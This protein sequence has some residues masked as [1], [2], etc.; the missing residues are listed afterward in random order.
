MKKIV[1]QSI[2]LT[3]FK[4]IRSLSI[5]FSER[6]TTVSG[7]NGTGKT[8]IFDAFLWLLFGKDSTGRSDSNFNIKTLGPDGKP[9]LKL[10]HS[11]IGVLSV[12]G[13]PVKLQRD[14]I[15]VWTKP[16]GTTQE[17]LTNHKTEFYVNDVKQPTKRDYD[18]TVGSIIPE[19]M[20]K[21]LTDPGFFPR[22]SPDAQ[23]EI[24]LDMAG[25]VSDQ[26][27]AALRPEFLEL[28]SQIQGKGLEVF[29]KEVAAKK[30]AVKDELSQI[31][32]R[33]ETAQRLRPEAEDW[34]AAEKELQTSRERIE[35]IDAQ[36]AD[37]TKLSDEET[38]RKLDIRKQIGDLQ[39]SIADRKNAIRREAEGGRTKA[40]DE[41]RELEHKVTLAKSEVNRAK[42]RVDMLTA[43]VESLNGRLANMRK[44][45]MD[46]NAEKLVFD[47][48]EFICPTCK[49]PL[50]QEDIEAKQR[51]LE[52]NFNTKKASRLKANREAGLAMKEKLSAKQDALEKAKADEKAARESLAALEAELDG[53]RG[54]VPDAP[55]LERLY[56]DDEECRSKL[57]QISELENQLTMDAKLPDVSDV[58]DEKRRLNFKIEDL[59]K[60]LGRRDAIKRADEEISALEERRVAANQSLAELEGMEALA[61][62]FQKEKDAELLRRINGMFSVV[63]FSFVASQLNGGE[64]LTC[65]CTVDGTPYPDVNNAGKINAGIDII[66]AII[67]S[68]GVCAPIFID[69]RESVNA[70]I[71]TE[72]Q[73]INLVVGRQERLS[74]ELQ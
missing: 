19:D 14:Y 44:E 34:K 48:G 73:V 59:L 11:V 41:V 67:R 42:E 51:E 33:I 58:V 49:R 56:A 62:D 66:N 46:I 65:V 32:A 2:A 4:G 37:R 35:Q 24:L 50:E 61:L 29:K 9:I 36:I 10:P 69:N 54:V 3:N 25:T 52:A 64:K 39:A 72:A 21:M 30:R 45:Y 57:N 23:K 38:R 8:T 7:E 6:V 18:A 13:T 40:Q 68:K 28:L 71:P 1:L 55:D 27:V 70:I 53:A 74:V 47:E 17:T 15:E 43:E 5:D 26:D 60:R 22:M 63:S 16:R 31:P 12:D 20:F